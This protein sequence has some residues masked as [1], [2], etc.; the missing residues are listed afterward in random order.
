MIQETLQKIQ[1]RIRQAEQSGQL[2]PE[3]RAE[4]LRLL[5]TL[6]AE[7]EE[8]CKTDADRARTM[9]Q[10]AEVST[11]EMSQPQPKM[12]LINQAVSGISASVEDFEKEHP[13]L[14]EVVNRISYLLSNMGI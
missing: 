11:R 14:V 1:N 7:I 2:Q 6:K 8:V 5:D 12:G 4:M 13:K 10:F 9:A 3:R